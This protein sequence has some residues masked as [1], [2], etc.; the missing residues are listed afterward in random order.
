[1][2]PVCAFAVL[3]IMDPGPAPPRPPTDCVCDGEGPR[4]RKK[5][6]PSATSRIKITINIHRRLF[7]PGV[8]FGGNFSR[9]FGRAGLDVD[10]DS[11]IF[12]LHWI[13][14]TRHKS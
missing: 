10:V 11:D 3:T 7:L 8:G 6:M 1:M 2:S 9:S 5:K 12:N 14:S 13:F 4:C